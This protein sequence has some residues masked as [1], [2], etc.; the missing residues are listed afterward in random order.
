VSSTPAP[1]A[2]DT[3]TALAGVLTQRVAARVVTGAGDVVEL[4]LLAG[5]V[6]FDERTAPRVNAPLTAAVPAD[7]ALLDRIDARTGCRVVVDAGYVRAG[8]VL[9]SHQLV[10]LGLR[11]RRVRRPANT[12]ELQCAS[13]EA[14]II[15]GAVSVTGTVVETNTLN[16]IGTL[17]RQVLPAASID[18]GQLTNAGPAVNQSTVDIDRWEV[19]RDL[20][21]RIGAQLFDAGDR[22]W[23]VRDQPA[24]GTATLTIT[25]GAG[26]MLLESDAG[27]DRD[28]WA[29]WVVLRYVWT[30]SNNVRQR[31]VGNRRITSGPYVTTNNLKIYLEDRETPTTQAQADAAAAALVARLVTRGRSVTFSAP[32]AYW[33]RP[34]D[35]VLVQLPTGD[36]VAHLVSAVTFDLRTGRMT[37]TTRLPDN[38]GAIGA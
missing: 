5:T 30:D 12:L 27:I 7:A 20:A 23:V 3:A 8:G 37:I 28:D 1:W 2:D 26:G 22:G 13:D 18:Y 6:T 17:V 19:C 9:D 25:P 33:V 38:T 15:D 11:S 21:D 32:S 29:N 4:D 14:L 35:T 36:P 31:I 34:G 16:A 24:I 10:D